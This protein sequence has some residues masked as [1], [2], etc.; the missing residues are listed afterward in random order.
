MKTQ[1]LM[2]DV[3]PPA[4]DALYVAFGGW[5][6]ALDKRDGSRRWKAELKGACVVVVSAAFG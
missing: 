4:D 2:R 6:F 3:L 1:G 5:V